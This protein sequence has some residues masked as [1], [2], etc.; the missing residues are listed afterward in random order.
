MDNTENMDLDGIHIEDLQNIGNLGSYICGNYESNDDGG[1]RKQLYPLQRGYTGTEVRA[2]SFVAS[3]GK[4]DNIKIENIV[5]ANGDA[6]GIEF[7]PSNSIEVGANI[8][9]ADIHAGAAL[10]TDILP[11]LEDAMPNKLPRACA[12]RYCFVEILFFYFFYLF[13]ES[14]VCGHGP[15]TRTSFIAQRS[16]LQIRTV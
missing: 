1:H 10:K 9:I 14:K 6:V 12:I 8:D 7:F 15:M 2:L 13:I 11:S 3:S 16:R 4:M 5:S